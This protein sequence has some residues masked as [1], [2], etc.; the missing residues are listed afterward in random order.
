MR[1]ERFSMYQKTFQ[2]SIS[3]L[4]LPSEKLQEIGYALIDQAA[5]MLDSVPHGPVYQRVPYEIRKTLLTQ[6]LPK[7]PMGGE[8]IL[9]HY[10][11]HIFPYPFGNTHPRFFAWV[12]PAPAP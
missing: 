5:T 8:A 6:P 3:P 1:K 11:K 12:N 2:T 9:A 4:A 7:E 10:R